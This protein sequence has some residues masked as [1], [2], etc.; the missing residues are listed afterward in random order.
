MPKVP[1]TSNRMVKTEKHQTRRQ[2]IENLNEE[3]ADV[4][5]VISLM[6]AESA[7]SKQD[8]I[9][10]DNHVLRGQIDSPEEMLT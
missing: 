2:N 7:K 4:V 1:L 5:R 9:E 10:I 8:E 6:A 3:V